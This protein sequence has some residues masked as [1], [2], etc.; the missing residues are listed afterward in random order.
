MASVTRVWN[1]NRQQRQALSRR[2]L[3]GGSMKPVILYI[4]YRN[5]LVGHQYQITQLVNATRLK[6]TRAGLV[7]SYR[8]GAIV[9]EADIDLFQSK[10]QYKIICT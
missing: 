5:S 7:T 6:V 4:T 8:V 9:P 2:K 10:P 1:H 3:R